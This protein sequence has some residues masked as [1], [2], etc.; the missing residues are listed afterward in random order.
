MNYINKM[1]QTLQF[2]N[3]HSEHPLFEDAERIFWKI[4]M[5]MAHMGI[6]LYMEDTHSLQPTVQDLDNISY[7]LSIAGRLKNLANAADEE[8]LSRIASV[9]FYALES[10]WGDAPELPSDLLGVEEDEPAR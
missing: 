10:L 2:K 7:L 9:Y 8:A 5:H 3:K 4:N 1:I 6:S